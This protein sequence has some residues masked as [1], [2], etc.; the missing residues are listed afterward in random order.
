MALRMIEVIGE[1]LGKG[2]PRFRRLPTFVSTYT[3]AKT[4]GY[5]TLIAK[6][7]QD[8]FGKNIL[9]KKD[10]PLEVE[11]IC[12]FS[13]PK[14][15]PKSI[16]SKMLNGDIPYTKK[17]DIDN[18]A[19]IVLDG[20]NGVAYEDDKQIVALFIKKHY[21]NNELEEPSIQVRIYGEI[22]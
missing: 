6:T 4:K 14:S 1:P 13:V 22:E 3:D 19:K 2:R 15:T 10:S 20:L 8:T 11:I 12:Q 7:W 18:I 9:F 17:P 5:E 16:K 21:I